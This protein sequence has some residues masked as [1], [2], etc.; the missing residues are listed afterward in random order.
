MSYLSLDSDI[1]SE[2][3]RVVKAQVLRSCDASLVG[4]IPTPRIFSFHR[5]GLGVRI[6]AFHAV[7][8]GSSPG[9]GICSEVQMAKRNLKLLEIEKVCKN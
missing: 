2:D 8:P 5:Y 9:I 4:S 1:K 3:G 6:A 7:G